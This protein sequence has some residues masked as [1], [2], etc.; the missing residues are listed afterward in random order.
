MIKLIKC[1]P[2]DVEALQ[3]ISIETFSATFGPYNTE[4]NLK[5]YLKKAYDIKI[6]QQ[7]LSNPNSEFYFAYEDSKI[8]G[9]L[10]INILDAQSEKMAD[11]FFFFL[12]IYVRENFKRH[13][14]GK[15]MLEFAVKRASDLGKNRL[16]L[17]V[18]EKNFAAQKF[19]YS[20][21]FEKY[22]SHRFTMG[23]SVQ[24]DFILKKELRK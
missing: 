15:K 20:L 9:Y 14:I 13:G 22:S 6:L 21:G 2:E 12:R 3:N 8:A 19:Y 1:T 10:K 5:G 17:G 18:W 16:W 7:E 23:D 24:I 11:N 4:A